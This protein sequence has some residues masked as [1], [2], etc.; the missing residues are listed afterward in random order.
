MIY[1]LCHHVID[2][3]QGYLS[4]RIVESDVNL[5]EIIIFVA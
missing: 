5:I 3:L 1:Y 4:L 2:S